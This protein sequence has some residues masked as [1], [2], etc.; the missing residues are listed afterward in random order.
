M[1]QKFI[2]VTT[3]P[4][5][6]IQKYKLKTKHMKTK[7][8]SINDVTEFAALLN[9]EGLIFHPDDD[10]RDYINMNT[11]E[12]FYTT[13]EADLRN[14]LMKQC[15]DVCEKAGADIYEVMNTQVENFS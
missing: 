3:E 9:N 13:D 6:A 15:F 5:I 10:F 11:N 8:Q 2:H 12:P 7:I 4:S 14:N 1:L